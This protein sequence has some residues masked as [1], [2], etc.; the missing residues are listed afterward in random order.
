MRRHDRNLA[1]A[2]RRGWRFFSALSRHRRRRAD[3]EP[4]RARTM[5]RHGRNLAGAERRNLRELAQLRALLR[6][7]PL[8]PTAVHVH[9]E[10]ARR[11]DGRHLRPRRYRTDRSTIAPTA[12]LSHRPQHCRTDRSTIAPTAALSHRPRHYADRTPKRLDGA[13]GLPRRRPRRRRSRW[14]RHRRRAARRP[15]D[16]CRPSAAASP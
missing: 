8:L 10:A 14:G 4:C 6:P 12:A 16:R 13:D 7:Q 2:E 11:R 3:I 5:Q 15:G 1:G 9:A